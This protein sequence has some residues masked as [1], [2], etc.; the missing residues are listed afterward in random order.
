MIRLSLKE[1]IFTMKIIYIDLKLG[2]EPQ[3][4]D[5]FVNEDLEKK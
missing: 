5:F 4:F 3:Q 2:N 1:Y